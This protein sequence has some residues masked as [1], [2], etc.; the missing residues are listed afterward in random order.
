M[1]ETPPDSQIHRTPEFQRIGG[2]PGMLSACGAMCMHGAVSIYEPHFA[3]MKLMRFYSKRLLDA[4]ALKFSRDH[5]HQLFHGRDESWA[6]GEYTTLFAKRAC[7]AIREEAE[8][9]KSLRF[10]PSRALTV[11]ARFTNEPFEDWTLHQE[12][13][14]AEVYFTGSSR[15]FESLA[16][17]LRI[18]RQ[19]LQGRNTLPWTPP[20]GHAIDIVVKELRPWEFVRIQVSISP[21]QMRLLADVLVAHRLCVWE[22]N[23]GGVHI[24]EEAIRTIGFPRQRFLGPVRVAI[25]GYGEAPEDKPEDKPADTADED[26]EYPCRP[27][28]HR[29]N[30]ELWFEG[31]TDDQCPKPL[32]SVV[33]RSHGNMGHP[34]LVDAVCHFIA[35]GSPSATLRCLNAFRCTTCFRK[36]KKMTS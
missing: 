13:S 30:D 6:S 34:R 14:E 3:I 17:V 35:C 11:A 31:V 4:I 2:L 10:V 21:K 24:E 25:F 15:N 33:A 16:Q 29:H 22:D 12:T 1:Y 7:G 32:R 18:A 23:E 9:N 28:S 5:E 20:E 8:I 36:T 26:D 19:T 27:K